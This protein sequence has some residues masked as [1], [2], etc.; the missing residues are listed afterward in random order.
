[1]S[2]LVRTSRIRTM[3]VFGREISLT[4]PSTAVW[5][6]V[7]TMPGMTNLPAA[8]MTVAP[9]GGAPPLCVGPARGLRRAGN[10]KRA[11]LVL[12]GGDGEDG[13]VADDGI[14]ECGG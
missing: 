5:L 3:P 1:M 13:G 6:C 8:S 11:L 7:S 4:L 14:G 12:A 9:A 2:S 10:E